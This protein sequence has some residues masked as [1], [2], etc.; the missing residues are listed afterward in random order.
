MEHE[1]CCHDGCHGH[2][3][4]TDAC[5]GHE[6]HHDHEG[7]EHACGCGCGCGHHHGGN[8][9]SLTMDEAKFLTRFAATPFLPLA[10]FLMRSTK[11]DE[12][13]SVGMPAVYLE[14][15]EDSMEAVSAVSALLGH[16]EAMGLITLDYDI[17]LKDYDYGAYETSAL[18]A[19]FRE[20]V[21]EGGQRPDFLFDQ[22]VLET[23]SM[24]L[25][26]LGVAV[27]EQVLEML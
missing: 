3:E 1:H 9:I 12:L 25:T 23:G 5:Q 2:H 16:L 13:E 10:R 14:A 8:E 19:A 26:D 17:A 7:P 15:P 27:M 24:A 18:Y 11:E 6:H 20:M 21:A 22:P 4:H